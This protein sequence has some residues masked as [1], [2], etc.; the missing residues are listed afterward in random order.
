MKTTHVV[1]RAVFL[2][3]VAVPLW[4]QEKTEKEE[5]RRTLT[6]T[7]TEAKRVV[8]DN[9][10]GAID[11]VGYDGTEVQLVVLKEICAE[12]DEKIREAKQD[13]VLEMKEEPNKIILY[14]DAPWRRGDGS[15]HYRGYHYYG[16]NVKHDFELRVPRKVSLYLRTV[17]EGEITV[18]DV[19]GEFEVKNVNAGISMDNIIGPAKISTVNGPVKVFFRPTAAT[20]PPA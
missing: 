5:I 3:L 13:V 8:V 2:L 10:D 15:Y 16:Y 17:N 12:S 9:L 20:M 19:E 1:R 18:K 4:S 11:V 6:F 7:G 14:V